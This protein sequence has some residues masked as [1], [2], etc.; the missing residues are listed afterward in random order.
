MAFAA[1][2][3]SAQ[4]FRT[5]AYP[6]VM[7][8][9]ARSSEA[10]GLVEHLMQAFIVPA[11]ATVDK[12][13][14]VR[15]PRPSSVQAMRTATGALLADL[16]DFHRGPRANAQPRQGYHGMSRSNFVKKDL[17]FAYDIFRDAVVPLVSNG[18]LLQTDGQAVYRR[19]AG[20]FE[21]IGGSKTCFGLADSMIELASQHGVT[22]DAWGANWTCFTEGRVQP[23]SDTPRLALRKTRERKG[24]TKQPTE[25]VLFDETSPVPKGLLDDVERINSYL[26][27]QRI[28]GVAFPGLRRIFNNGD[29]TDYAWN[30]G[31]RYY[32]LRGG[33][34]YEAWSAERRRESIM[35]NGEAVT[36]VDLRAS[37][38]TLLH[39]LLGQPFDANVDP[40]KF[41]DWPRAVI[42]AWVSQA[43][44]GS[45]S[46]P[47][48]WSDDAEDAYEDERPGRWLQDE[49]A[50]REVGAVV[51]DRHPTLLHLETCG[52]DTLD[53]QYHEAEILR[54][55]ME[56]L[57]FQRDI[58]VL[59]VHDA[60]IVPLSGAEVAKRVLEKAFLSY[61][62]GV[63]GRPSTAIPRVTLKKPKGT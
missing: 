52:I 44:G 46:R 49:F 41:S 2:R 18:L 19:V 30:K 57:M 6:L 60:L 56:T 23:S 42:K 62:E 33:H 40:Y 43:I 53:L 28:S 39:A 5:K 17:G 55:A 27:T 22:I 34:R 21:V 25:V 15:E 50:I 3:Q 31:G 58:A 48:Q 7:W 38:I 45:N 8:G 10:K 9:G 36:E 51:I 1:S 12:E 4:A 59:P 29:T 61:V 37:H 14:V 11:K 32:S 24:R 13:G 35:I 20:R 63:V 47:F 16:F 54:S 26:S